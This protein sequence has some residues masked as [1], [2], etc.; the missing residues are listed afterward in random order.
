MAWKVSKRRRARPAPRERPKQTRSMAW[1][2]A[3]DTYDSLCCQGYVSLAANPEICAGVD[4]IARLVGSMT[5]HLME[6]REDGVM[7]IIAD[8]MQ[9]DP[10]FVAP[11]I[12]APILLAVLLVM[13]LRPLRRRKRR[14]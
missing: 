3:P 12:G 4:T 14:G 6:N 11:V 2:C 10:R 8:A 13:I 9:I 1:L 7:R 5:I